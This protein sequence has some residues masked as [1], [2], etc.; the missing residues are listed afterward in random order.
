MSLVPRK[1]EDTSTRT[2]LV[3]QTFLR[4][5]QGASRSLWVNISAGHPLL[6]IVMALPM[7]AVMLVMLIIVLLMLGFTLLVMA[8]LWAIWRLRGGG[9]ELY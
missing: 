4:T 2:V 9:A 8:L 3:T 5:G 6:K 7:I 1:P